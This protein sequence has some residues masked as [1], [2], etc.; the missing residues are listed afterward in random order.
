MVRR[1]ARVGKGIQRVGGMIHEGV[2]RKLRIAGSD[3][4][5]GSYEDVRG[6]MKGGKND[7]RVKEGMVDGLC[8]SDR[9]KDEDVLQEKINQII[10]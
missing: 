8:H 4:G 1:C 10:K 9:W 2:G 5:M 3:E 7:K 6:M